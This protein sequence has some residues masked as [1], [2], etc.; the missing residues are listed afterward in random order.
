VVINDPFQ[1]QLNRDSGA[2]LKKGRLCG[3]G[4][5]QSYDMWFT[6]EVISCPSLRHLQMVDLPNR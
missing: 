2:L 4:G 6:S 1:N 5:S 3:G